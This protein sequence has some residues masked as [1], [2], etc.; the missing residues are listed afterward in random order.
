MA[1]ETHA[2]RLRG[3]TSSDT[4]VAQKTYE[5]IGFRKD[6]E[7]KNYLLPISED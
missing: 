3:S 7:F 2:E 4:K 6:S 1:H 5:P